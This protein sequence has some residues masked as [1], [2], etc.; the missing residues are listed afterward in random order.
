M[1]AGDAVIFTEALTHGTLPWTAAHERRLLR[2]LYS[3]TS[4]LHTYNQEWENIELSDLERALVGP[5][6]HPGA[7]I[8]T[9][10]NESEKNP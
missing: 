3:P 5:P 6:S 1:K 9:L 7:D 4:H 2:Y 8:G 10:L